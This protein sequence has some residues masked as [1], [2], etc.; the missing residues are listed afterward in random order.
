MTTSSIL[1]TRVLAGLGAAAVLA[2]ATFTANRDMLER[3]ESHVIELPT[4]IAT[5]QIDGR[6][7]S[8]S[9]RRAPEGVTPQV[10]TEWTGIAGEPI[11]EVERSGRDVHVSTRCEPGGWFG[12]WPCNAALEVLVPEGVTLKVDNTTG[13]VALN[14]L[15]G[16]VEV[17]TTTGLV[18][19]S[20]LSGPLTMVTTTG[21]IMLDGIA[22][23]TID[24]RATTGAISVESVTAP[25]S[26]T[27]RT[28]TGAV[29]VGLPDDGAPYNVTGTTGTGEREVTVATD[30]AAQ[31]TV[32]ASATTG[33]VT[34]GYGSG[35]GA[36]GGE[37]E[38]DDF[39]RHG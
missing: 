30:P 12:D 27:A 6:L 1:A 39:Q 8:V 25:Q 3:H 35:S 10:Q 11:T 31:R 36:F 22:S 32:E 16:A 23:E 19:G 34:V 38:F 5:L 26:V 28:T 14:D 18:A 9:V 20:D 24:L 7:G 29:Y 21:A 4:A 2:G 15:D 17:V 37:V 33:S 13:Y